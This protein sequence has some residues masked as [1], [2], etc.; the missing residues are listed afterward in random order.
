[1]AMNCKHRV[2]GITTVAN[3]MALQQAEVNIELYGWFELSGLIE[4]VRGALIAACNT[5]MT[6]FRT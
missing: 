5:R 1:M 2:L 4:D 6:I 3:A